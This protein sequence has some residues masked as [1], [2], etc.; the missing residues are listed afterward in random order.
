MV[1]RWGDEFVAGKK[2]EEAARERSE[3]FAKA[4]NR[5]VD[6]QEA[7]HQVAVLERDGR[8]VVMVNGREFRCE[9]FLAM[10][11]GAVEPIQAQP[12][13]QKAKSI[14]ER[15]KSERARKRSAK[16]HLS[17]WLSTN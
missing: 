14:I 10:S 1:L 15:L 4:C 3:L 17:P 12:P 11:T 6:W 2:E 16:A 7:G 8:V 9:E 13:S 5:R